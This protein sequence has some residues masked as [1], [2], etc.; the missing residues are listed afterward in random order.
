MNQAR[1]FVVALV[2]VGCTTGTHNVAS[3]FAKTQTIGPEGGTITILASDDPTIAG[4][5]LVIPPGA[6]SEAVK[7]GIY[8]KQPTDSAI[9]GPRVVIEP[10]R[11]HFAVA[12]TL[13]I[14]AQQIAD[15]YI[16][17]VVV[18]GEYPDAASDRLTA[19]S[20]DGIVILPLGRAGSY[21]ALPPEG[22]HGPLRTLTI[23]P[24][25]P[26]LPL[27]LTVALVATGT[28][29]DGS[30]LDLSAD[31]TWSSSDESV[32]TVSSAGLA[33]SVRIGMTTITAQIGG[34]TTSIPLQVTLPLLVGI[35]IGPSPLSLYEGHRLQMTVTGTFSDGST[36]DV[37]AMVSWHS[38]SP[39]I[40]V[41]DAE[42]ELNG[43]ARGTGTVSANIGSLVA[44]ATVT[45]LPFDVVSLTLTPDRR[46][47]PT[48]SSLQLSLSGLY[49]DG[50]TADLTASPE[51]VW[52][53]SDSSV[54]NPGS[55]GLVASGQNVGSAV[56]TATLGTVSTSAT[57]FVDMAQVV[58]LAITPSPISVDLGGTQQL[59]ATATYSNG[60]MVDVT[61]RVTWS[62]SNS[63]VA[64][65]SAAGVVTGRREG[66]VSIGCTLAALS[67][68]APMTVG[69]LTVVSVYV[70]VAMPVALANTTTRQFTATAKY[71]D[72][73]TLD[74]TAQA[75]WTTRNPE[76]ATVSAGLVTGVGVGTARIDVEFA[77]HQGIL[78]VAVQPAPV[79]SYAITA[80]SN[81]VP[82]G[83][84]MQLAAIATRVD[85][86]TTDFAQN[87][88]WISS[89]ETIL[90]VSPD[91]LAQGVAEG[92]VT[93]T[94]SIAGFSDTIVLT[95]GP[96]DLTQLTVTPQDGHFVLG[97][98]LQLT[99]MA[100]Y[101]D[102]THQDL[103][104]AV[105]WVSQSPDIV[106]VDADGLAHS[107]A[108]GIAT[109]RATAPNGVDWTTTVVTVDPP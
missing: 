52:T 43:I 67:A 53:T 5:Q 20:Q 90:T 40:F 73:S 97:S 92:T 95:V 32:A 57:L 33:S 34:V 93:V 109:I 79:V 50:S 82:L 58:S 28:F 9:E 66:T 106:S 76:Y 46:H 29:D 78:V 22:E 74:V 68:T 56:I 24:T 85:N 81:T 94:A 8:R 60:S 7:F 54:A 37:T 4:T 51:V 87:G 70:P 108:T 75:T 31:A 13:S 64:T 10:Q 103:T 23:T 96:P 104:S 101:S 102:G 47:I 84:T 27:G 15:A 88:G 80:P 18:V 77:S 42:S 72:G 1:H 45:V 38:D 25:N 49:T 12:A 11:Q 26:T 89:D 41:V 14:P 36:H 44:T 83:A 6:L 61:S 105:T 17:F 2:L 98:T 107:V 100:D 16:H 39:P 63:L 71:S 21:A 19:Q 91:G 65:V 59:V 3:L 35:Q 55:S 48:S 62:S 86:T 69:P 99:A 30:T